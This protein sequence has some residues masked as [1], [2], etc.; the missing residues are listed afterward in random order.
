ME[1]PM[2]ELMEIEPPF[3]FESGGFADHTT[4]LVRDCWYIAGRSGEIS[5]NI[6]SRRL[7][8]VDVALYR[9][10]AGEPIA[11]RNRCPHRSFPLAKGKLVGDILVCG[12]HGM[13]FDPSGHCV[14]M[15]SMPIVPTNASVRT[16][17]VVERAPLVWIWMGDPDKAD[18]ALVPG[19]HWLSDPLWKSVTGD[20]HMQSDY[21]SMHENL[22]D[23]THFPFLHPG[24]VGT[25]E[26]ARSKLNV[27]EE[28]D[29]VIIDRALRNSAPPGIYGIPA[30]IMDKKVDRLSE[31]RFAS[32]AIHTA[33]AKIIDL[34]PDAGK[35]AE[36]RFNITHLITPETQT[37]IHYWWFNSRNFKLDDADAD[38]F[39]SDASTQAYL[40]DVDALQWILEVVRKD[41]EKQFDLNFAPDKPAL[42]MRRSL[43]HRAAAEAG[44]RL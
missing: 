21:V 4:P 10:L 16:F 44:Y 2:S 26:Y 31:A 5:R 6:I 20:F 19:T 11:V 15:P 14:N 32:P 43:Y 39:L 24:T 28:G 17:P 27:R 38:Q 29:V 7:L 13:Q 30:G 23:Q 41:H 36:Y 8:G 40:E 18:E 22:L 34:A 35:Q 3:V 12:Y 42:L 33:F 37:S 1:Q 9:T 25:P